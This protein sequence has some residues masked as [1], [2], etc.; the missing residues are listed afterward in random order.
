MAGGLSQRED[1]SGSLL[2]PHSEETNAWPRIHGPRLGAYEPPDPQPAGKWSQKTTTR[3]CLT[4]SVTTGEA[5]CS[6]SGENEGGAGTRD[7]GMVA[8][9]AQNLLE[10]SG[11]GG[12]DPQNAVGLAGHRVRLRNLGDRADHVPHPVRRH[13]SF[14]VDLDESFDC[15][16]QRGGLDLGCE[17]SDDTAE[18]EPI[19]PSFGGRGGQSDVLS[20][21][22]EA[23]ATM[24]GKTRKDLVINFIKTQH[25]LLAFVDHTIGLAPLRA[26]P[27]KS[28]N[29]C[30]EQHWASSAA[31][32]ASALS[33]V[34]T[35]VLR[36]GL[37]DQ[38]LDG[39]E[40]SY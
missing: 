34:P 31:C 15:P 20:E 16:A 32:Q 11:I 23:L 30:A 2:Q 29:G 40:R 21:H 1:W 39:S 19:N 27:F 18:A 6:E 3:Q 12:A 28:D 13:P 9:D 17:A 37:F 22:R 4:S 38:S 5:S 25:T 14:A 24:V 33:D 7:A 8:D 35:D 36:R 26:L 10:V